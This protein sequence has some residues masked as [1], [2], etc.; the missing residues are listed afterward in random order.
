V[1]GII[2]IPNLKKL[3]TSINPTNTIKPMPTPTAKLAKNAISKNSPII[4]HTLMKMDYKSYGLA[5]DEDDYYLSIGN[6]GYVP[7]RDI[8]LI[9]PTSLADIRI[10][11]GS[12]DALGWC[13]ETLKDRSGAS[14]CKLEFL[15]P[16]MNLNLFFSAKS[17][18]VKLSD[19]D[20]LKWTHVDGEGFIS[21][22]F[23]NETFG[24]LLVERGNK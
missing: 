22:G 15:N 19:A 23:P 6:I 24:R 13:Q 4:I 3:I 10:H 14:F 2:C 8:H 21:A 18:G 16:K 1:S 5:E 11:G 7:V 9:F 12:V 17:P 20:L